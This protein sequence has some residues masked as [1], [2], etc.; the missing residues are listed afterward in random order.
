[1]T[2]TLQM[3]RRTMLTG[4]AVAGALTPIIVSSTVQANEEVAAADALKTAKQ[5]KVDLAKLPREKVAL[6]KPPFVHTH[7]QKA[8]GGPKIKEFT[9]TIQE[10]KMILDKDGTEINAMTFDGSVP[11]PLMVV[12]QDDYVELTL[13]NP[14][15]NTL[16]HNIDFHA[17][18]G[19]LG[20]GALTVVNPGESTVFRFKATK[21]GVFVYH[22]A[23]P[24]MVPWHVTSGMN[25]AI[26]VL[27]REGL[28]DGKG[29]PLVYDK[30]YY[31][32]EQD[33]YVPRD[34]TGKFKKYDSPG[35]AYDETVAVMKTLTPT[36]IVFNGAVGALTGENAMT[37]KVGETVLIVHSQANRDTRP[38]LIGGHGEYV[39]ATGKFLNPPDTDQETWFIPGGTA[40]AAIYTFAQPGIYA[41]VNHNLIEAFE[42]G[43]AAHFKVT[44]EWDDDLMTS[45]RAPSAS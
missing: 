39:W 30:I 14:E 27:P 38:H 8:D 25:G 33:F 12:H 23:P 42:L 11:G 10:K 3:T 4:A 15:T 16:Q 43:A 7:Q 22:C 17:A 40:G 5:T 34:E 13:V 36:H 28:K 21:A 2:N 26:M 45:V 41:Y 1:M 32:G 18:T 19:A 20:G 44:G 29:R 31:V 6:V 9:L 35:E 37:A 24:G